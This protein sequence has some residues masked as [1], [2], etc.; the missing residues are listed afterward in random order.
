MNQP[1]NGNSKKEWKRQRKTRIPRKLDPSTLASFFAPSSGGTDSSSQKE[2]PR[3][4]Q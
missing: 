1:A 2:K 3:M 4:K